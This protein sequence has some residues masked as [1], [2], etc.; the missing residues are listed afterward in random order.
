MY[1]CMIVVL[2]L[3]L[4]RQVYLCTAIPSLDVKPLPRLDAAPINTAGALASSY[5]WCE[6]MQ[7]SASLMTSGQLS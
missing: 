6:V 7:A 1:L 3:N 2:Q 4:F 5:M